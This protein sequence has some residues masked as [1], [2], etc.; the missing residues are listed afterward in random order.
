MLFSG[1][2]NQCTYITSMIQLNE[3]FRSS[4]KFPKIE[5]VPGFRF[6]EYRSYE[7]SARNRVWVDRNFIVF[8]LEGRKE[9]HTAEETYKLSYNRALF[10]RRGGYLMS[11]IPKG[12]GVFQSLLFFID[13]AFLEQFA[14]Q[15][16]ALLPRT[17][18][19]PKHAGIPIR[20]TAPISQFYYTALPYF[21]LPLNEARRR[22]LGL[23]FEEL[24]LTLIAEPANRHFAAFLS[25]LLQ[26]KPNIRS[27]M[28]QNF[29]LRLP[30]EDFARLAQRSLSAFKRDFRA[31]Y[32]MPPGQWLRQRRLQ[33][34]RLLLKTTDSPVSE[35][36]RESGF[37]NA[38][39][40]SQAFREQFGRSPSAWRGR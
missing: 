11:E 17:V 1:L 12:R 38:S 20:V 39:H 6:V 33:H 3:F 30:M 9:I 21:N 27:V 16:A 18:R 36:A 14:R 5:A 34:A 2:L 25:S 10:L 32:G 31:A 4:G 19:E 26:G 8:V 24:L 15:H 13:D 23:K 29:F 7:T 22:A 40:F 37:E 35:I 28:E